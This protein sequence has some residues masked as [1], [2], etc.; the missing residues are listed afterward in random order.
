MAEMGETVKTETTEVKPPVVEPEKADSKAENEEITRLKAALSRANSEAA[1]WKRNYKA[2]LDEAK[3]KEME[4]SERRKAELEE[5]EALRKDKRINTYKAKLMDAGVDG[6]A[7]DLMAKALPDGVAEEYFTATKTFLS[8]QRQAIETESLK[9][10]PQLS[11]GAPPTGNGLKT[12]EDAKY[13]R[14]FGL[15]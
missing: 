1:E 5:L 14:W 10:Q 2:T 7:A 12:E 6:A 15:A 13:D 11:V 9:K 8:N 4:A 3:Q